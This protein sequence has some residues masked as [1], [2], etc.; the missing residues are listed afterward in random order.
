MQLA[1]RVTHAIPLVGSIFLI[2][3]TNAA[4]GQSNAILLS[5]SCEDVSR[6]GYIEYTEQTLLWPEDIQ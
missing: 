5:S 6:L 1:L 4:S 3:V 2:I